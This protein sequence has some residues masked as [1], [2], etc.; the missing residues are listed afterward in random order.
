MRLGVFPAS[1][2]VGECHPEVIGQPSMSKFNVD[3]IASCYIHIGLGNDYCCLYLHA[4]NSINMFCL[5]GYDLVCMMIVDEN[6][7]LRI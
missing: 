4:S 2:K 5:V 6:Y 3:L 1:P 7:M